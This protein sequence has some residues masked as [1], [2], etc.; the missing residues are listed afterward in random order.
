MKNSI[1]LINYFLYEVK[2]ILVTKINVFKNLSEKQLNWRPSANK[3]SIGD[4]FD[5]LLITHKLYYDRMKNAVEEKSKV[6]GTVRGSEIFQHT[7]PGKMILKSVDPEN[8]KKLKTFKVFKPAGKSVSTDIVFD[9]AKEVDN[10]RLLA[11]N[12]REVNLGRIKITSPLSRFIRMNIGD[13]LM[14]NLYHDNRHLNQAKDILMD[15]D[16][17]R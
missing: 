7:L 12:L 5:H 9:F 4:C 13:A 3:W 14:I 15:N 10:M 17:L 1:E 11:E 16:L 2:L 8:S 6:A